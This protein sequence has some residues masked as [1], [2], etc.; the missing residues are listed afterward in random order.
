MSKKRSAAGRLLAENAHVQVGAR[1]KAEAKRRQFVDWVN[2]PAAAER[3]RR[4]N[5]SGGQVAT[6]GQS[7][8]ETS[9]RAASA[10]LP[11]SNRRRH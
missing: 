3:R 1:A 6:T 11:E 5:A 10:G 7:E 9:V 8:P 2:D 4:A